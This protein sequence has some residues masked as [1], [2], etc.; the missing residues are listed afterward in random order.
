MGEKKDE[1]VNVV[2]IYI[3]RWKLNV[4]RFGKPFWKLFLYMQVQI[5]HLWRMPK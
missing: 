2:E 4:D 3:V 1:F 5:C